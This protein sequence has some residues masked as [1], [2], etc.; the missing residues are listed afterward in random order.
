MKRLSRVVV[1]VLLTATAVF[2]A[3]F[4]YSCGKSADGVE[5]VVIIADANADGKTLM[6]VMEEMEDAGELS[7]KVKD[8]MI[9][10]INGT[11]NDIDYDPC[12]MLYTSD[13]ENSS[14]AWGEYEYEGQ[15]LGS[16]NYGADNLIVKSGEIYVWVYQEF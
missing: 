16:A 2:A 7:Y 11:E 8:G 4:F 1:G 15:I 3:L 5:P 13:A 9:V 14:T 6:S 10:E 12:W